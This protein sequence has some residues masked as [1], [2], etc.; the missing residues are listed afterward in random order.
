MLL[1]PLQNFCTIQL[2]QD[3]MPYFLPNTLSFFLPHFFPESLLWRIQIQFGNSYPNSL[4]LNAATT[5]KANYCTV[6]HQIHNFPK[7]SI[8]RLESIPEERLIFDRLS[9]GMLPWDLHL[10]SDPAEGCGRTM[11]KNSVLVLGPYNLYPK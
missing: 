10:T 9:L 11:H 2:P 1:L 4:V 5:V 6:V 8:D 7:K 3:F